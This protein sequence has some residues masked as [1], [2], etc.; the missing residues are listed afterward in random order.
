M[1]SIEP[2]Y[3]VKNGYWRGVE[4]MYQVKNGYW[5]IIDSTIDWCE[6]NYIITVYIAEFFNT[7]SSLP[8]VLWAFL[9]FFLTRKYVNCESRFSFA[10]LMLGLVGLGSVAFHGTLRYHYQLLDEIPMLL[11]DLIL[12]YCCFMTETER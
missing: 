5:G 12:V 4:P 6:P 9:G 11:M 8:M 2:M 1:R 7:I 3:Q 10:F